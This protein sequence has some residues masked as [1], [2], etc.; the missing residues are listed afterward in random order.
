MTKK[1]LKKEP[2]SEK[3]LAVKGQSILTDAQALKVTSQANYLAAIALRKQAKDFKAESKKV[4]DPMYRKA[5]EAANEIKSQWN[6]IDEPF[7]TVIDL[8]TSAMI[9][10]EGKQQAIADEKQ[11]KLDEKL[12]EA[13][14]NGETPPKPALVPVENKAHQAEGIVWIDNWK[15]KVVNLLALVQRAD[16]DPAYLQYLE[17]NESALNAA[18][19]FTRDQPYDIP[20]VEFY[21]D[22]YPRGT[23]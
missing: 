11:R 14:A 5:K 17:P 2:V 8:A 6:K 4:F 19:K 23:R 9:D 18:A 16:K 10:W 22:R 12:A 1:E 21:N 15:A 20:G 7:D 3:Q 13:E